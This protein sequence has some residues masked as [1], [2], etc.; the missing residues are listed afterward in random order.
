M[1]PERRKRIL[2]LS[3]VDFK[4][5]SIQVIRKTPE[6][7][8]KAGWEV[9]YI[10]GRDNSVNGDYFYE[11][12]INP[13]GVNVHRFIIPLTRLHGLLNNVFWKAFWFRVRN[14]LL[15]WDLALKAIKLIRKKDFDVIYGYEIPGVLAVRFMRFL[16]VRTSAKV[17][18][19][20][21]GVL[22]VKEW[23][24]KNQKFRFYSNWDAMLALKAK[25]DLCI[26]TND[27]SQ[28]L[29]VLKEVNSPN[30][31]IL[32]C[33]NGVDIVKLNPQITEEIR[34]E[35]YADRSKKYLLSISRLDDHKRIDRSL[36]VIHK[37]VSKFD[38]K[39]FRFIVIGGGSEYQNLIRLTEALAIK[40]YVEFLG[41]IK[42]NVVPYHLALSDLFLSMYTSTNVGNP[43]LEAIRHNKIIITLN[44]GDTGDWIKHRVSGLIYDVDDDKDLSTE[45]YEKIASDVVE[46]FTSIDLFNSLERGVGE[47]E[48]ARLWTWEERFDAELDRVEQLLN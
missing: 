37:M 6:A 3:G 36:R 27:G 17:V 38:F 29:K 7:Y 33:S 22:Y 11:S 28:G 24:R 13:D 18:T 4:E 32:F 40:P 8:V 46:V 15:V 45:D 21:Q 48:K 26:M 43:L 5:K 12:I 2:F 34:K 9:H 41:P 14:I 39:D 23:L 47:V 1:N 20:F 30:K 10:V 31:N 42:H 16:G 25:A 19:R 35:L 44:N